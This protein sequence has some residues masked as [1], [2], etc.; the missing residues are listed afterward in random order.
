MPIVTLTTEWN[1]ND[2]YTGAVKGSILAGCPNIIL[3]DISHQ[4][5]TYNFVQAAFVLRSCYKNFPLGTIHIVGVKS[6]PKNKHPYLAVKFADQYFLTANNGLIGLISGEKPKE[7]IS[8]DCFGEYSTF[9][10]LDIF[11]KA[12]CHLAKGNDIKELGEEIK[13]LEKPVQFL[14]AYDQSTITGSV[15]Y[16][17]SFSNAI[18]NIT[19]SLFN[20]IGKNVI[21]KSIFKVIIIKQKKLAKNIMMLMKVN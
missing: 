16:I 12:A 15:I 21:L 7:I 19:E 3:L 14:P 5:T 13:S 2:Y 18:T 20:D 11:A 6:E 8:I 10:E 9:P 17:D 1:R 4:I